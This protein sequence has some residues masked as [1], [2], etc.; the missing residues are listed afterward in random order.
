MVQGVHCGEQPYKVLALCALAIGLCCLG[1]L[2]FRVQTD[3]QHLWV[4]ANSL[5]AK[6]KAQYEVWTCLNVKASPD[7]VRLVTFQLDG[8][9]YQVN[10]GQQYGEDDQHVEYGVSSWLNLANLW[11]FCTSLC[12]TSLCSLRASFLLPNSS[13][14]VGCTSSAVFISNAVSL[15]AFPLTPWKGHPPTPAQIQ[16]SLQCLQ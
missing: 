7:A 3:P 16:W 1:L 4:G 10:A 5:A 12:S 14:G 13:A 6:E 11:V 9:S 2:R 8:A 15:S